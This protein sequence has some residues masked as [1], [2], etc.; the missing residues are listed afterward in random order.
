MAVNATS[1]S[2]TQTGQI[3]SKAGMEVFGDNLNTFLTMLTTQLQNQDPTSPLDAN[4]M[5]AQL[6]S[7]AGVEQQVHMNKNLESLI[8]LQEA[9]QNSSAV[10]YIGK[11]IEVEGNK[12]SNTGQGGRF[13]YQLKGNA[14]SAT[15]NIVT[16]TGQVV[17]SQPISSPNQ[18]LQKV[19]WAG[20]TT[21]GGA[22]PNGTY[23]VTITAKDATGKAV[24]ADIWTQGMVESVDVS[25]DTPKLEVAGQS[26][27]LDKVTKVSAPTQSTTN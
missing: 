25:G 23:S 19:Y 13:S 5:T 8:G 10:S 18:S 6:V 9:S 2:T 15:M 21:G 11:T 14:V 17:F 27:S 12:I 26:I 24:A 22:A 16:S 7:F 1:A 20:G 4:Q 3:A